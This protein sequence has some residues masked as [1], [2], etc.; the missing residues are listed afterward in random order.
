MRSFRNWRN[1]LRATSTG[2][3]SEL[4][5][6]ELVGIRDI[7]R[8]NGDSER[9][10]DSVFKSCLNFSLQVDEKKFLLVVEDPGRDL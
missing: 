1:C 9:V 10:R 5:T 2:G 4:R 8:T 7:C 3:T 6:I